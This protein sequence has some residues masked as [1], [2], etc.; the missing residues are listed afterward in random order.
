MARVKGK[1][2]KPELR[3][4]KLL[5]GMGYRFRLHRRDLP[6]TPDLVFPGRRAVIFMHGCFWHRHP[7]P[8]CRRSRLPKTRTDFWLPKLDANVARD[9]AA[10]AALRALGWR[11]LTVWECETM[12]ARRADLVASLT[13]FLGPAGK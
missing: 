6:G 11:V 7:D 12:P 3:L 9:A 4:R 10:E 5:H 1:D 2:T 8:D 13:D